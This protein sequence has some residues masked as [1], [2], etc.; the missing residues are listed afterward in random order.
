LVIA[1]WWGAGYPLKWV[2]QV[3]TLNYIYKFGMAILLLPLLYVAHNMID[4][5]L[6]KEA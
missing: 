1:F 5:Y 2:L 4:R 6:K 3:G